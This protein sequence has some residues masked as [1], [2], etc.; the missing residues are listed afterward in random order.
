MYGFLFNITM[1]KWNQFA[2]INAARPLSS[3]RKWKRIRKR[4]RLVSMV[5]NE[6]A[7]NGNA[8][9]TNRYLDETPS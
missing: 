9:K 3:T 6:Q 7:T 5:A 4:H 2:F 1:I 8:T